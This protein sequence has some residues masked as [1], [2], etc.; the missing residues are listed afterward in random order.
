MSMGPQTGQYPPDKVFSWSPWPMIKHGPVRVRAQIARRGKE[1]VYD[2]EL[3]LAIERIQDVDPLYPL[4]EGTYAL[5]GDECVYDL[6]GFDTFDNGSNLMLGNDRVRAFLEAH[7]GGEVAFTPITV[8]AK[9]GE[10]PGAWWVVRIL[11]SVEGIDWNRV[12]RDPKTG[13]I[14]LGTPARLRDGALGALN[15][16]LLN[17]RPFQIMVSNS[18]RL[19]LL[20][21]GL[22]DPV[23]YDPDS[24]WEKRS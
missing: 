4:P 9:D 5:L 24:P 3:D 11:N 19:A 14:L 18:L 22:R 12:R 17:E 15:I 23:A 10:L 1:G 13:G 21:S 8:Q 20:Q 16:A 6:K 7:C 2:E